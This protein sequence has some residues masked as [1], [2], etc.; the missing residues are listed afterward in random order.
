[1]NDDASLLHRYAI[2]GAQDAFA[3]LVRRHLGL[4][5]HAAHRQCG[6]DPHRAEEV[7]QL[8]FTDLA[9][10]ADALSRRPLLVAWLHTATRYAAT[11][12]RRSEQRRLAREHEAFAMSG[13]EFAPEPDPEWERLRPLI[14]D[15]LQSLGERDRAAVLL[16]FFE[17]RSYAELAASFDVS[18]DAA[19]VRVNRALE[20]LRAA[21]ARR[22]LVSTASA[23]S[24]ALVQPALA[25]TPAGLA[26]H[27]VSTSITA[28]ATTSATIGTA[29]ASHAVVGAVKIAALTAGTVAALSLGFALTHSSRTPRRSTTPS[30]SV[31][32]F[33]RT[34]A[35]TGT[36]GPARAT[37][38]GSAA[39]APA[40]ALKIP[41]RLVP[42][43]ATDALALYLALPPLPSDADANELNDRAAH[44]RG[45]LTILPSESFVRL[46]DAL[47]ARGGQ[48]E[49]RLRGIAFE[50][51]TE[52]D[53]TVAARWADAVVPSAALDAG[54]RLAYLRQAAVAWAARDFDAAYAWSDSRPDLALS[55]DL[56]RA[57]ILALASTDGPRALVLA[58]ARGGD[59]F[60]KAEDRIVLNWSRYDPAAT[61][62]SL[63]VA[64]LAEGRFNYAYESALRAWYRKKPAAALDWLVA[65][66]PPATSLDEF[67]FENLITS[68]AV[69]NLPDPGV[70]ATAL[71]GRP[72][73]SKYLGPLLKN[74][75]TQDPAAAL[76]WLDALPDAA[77]RAELLELAADQM[78]MQPDRPDRYLPLILRLPPGENR[79]AKITRILTTLAQISPDA[80][81]AWLK[82]HDSPEFAG[83]AARMNG[84]P[85]GE[86]AATDPDAALVRLEAMPDGPAK[87]MATA[88]LAQNWAKK[89]PASAARWYA[90]RLPAT[91][92]NE[93]MEFAMMRALMR[94]TASPTAELRGPNDSEEKLARR[95]TFISTTRA[96][97][98]S[99][100]LA[101]LRWAETL[102]DPSLRQLA[103]T[104]VSATDG[105]PLEKQ[106]DLLA[107]IQSPAVRS[108]S[109]EELLGHW[110]QKDPAAARAWLD[111]HDALSAEQSA[112]L[113][114]QTEENAKRASAL[115]VSR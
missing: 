87:S 19:R 29:T 54:T 70:V 49:N 14:D 7:A 91:P 72:E 110:L 92:Q 85:V 83:V 33:P 113:L 55:A 82:A 69:L 9:R 77:L 84:R 74:W 17:N 66:P 41:P 75:Q 67:K 59:F 16:R 12:I 39:A 94:A 109:L 62:R 22:G 15:A 3:E 57:L 13:A 2:E 98:Q 18:E 90:A 24:L 10:K 31:A 58:R 48:A 51:W 103:I 25:T 45:L 52:R 44:L 100:S 105:R 47:A 89:D 42:A 36:P 1:M 80:A 115:P 107:Q 114:K 28:A 4:V 68:G 53:A 40:P 32:E 86:L 50:V 35:P 20:K 63:G 97:A 23:L 34:A 99:D 76:V 56:A 81:S 61:L 46:L 108:G 106:A 65:Q 95:R 79:D 101:A 60:P 30:A 88:S 78:A 27:I 96:W 111:S 26:A 71:L 6:G 21:L 37:S 102:P 8:V 104:V 5:Y 73:Q 11:Q 43:E 93:H 38:I 112:R 64:A